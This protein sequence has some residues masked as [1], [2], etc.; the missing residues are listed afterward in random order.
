MRAAERLKCGGICRGMKPRPTVRRQ[1]GPRRKRRV[2]CLRTSA[3]I[4]PPLVVIAPSPCLETIETR[5]EISMPRVGRKYREAVEQ[6]V[7]RRQSL[8]A[9]G[10]LLVE[11]ACQT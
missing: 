10:V 9:R 3:R 5:R 11:K 7:D 1:D 6:A 2:P 8:V 4:P